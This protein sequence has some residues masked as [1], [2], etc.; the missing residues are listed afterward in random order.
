MHLD[1]NNFYRGGTALSKSI[2]VII[3]MQRNASIYCRPIMLVADKCAGF[4][5]ACVIN[6]VRRYQEW[7]GR[8]C[9]YTTHY[10]R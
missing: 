4:Y 7:T 1:R 5:T 6:Q 3:R 9:L 10:R 2:A 8:I